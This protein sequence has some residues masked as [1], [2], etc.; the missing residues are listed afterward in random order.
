MTHILKNIDV[1]V[2]CRQ[3][4]DFHISAEVIA[5][6]QRLLAEG[7][8]G[9]SYEC[10]P[11]LFA[12]LLEPSALAS[13]ERAWSAL[14]STV[15]SPVRDVSP[16]DSL[17]V[18]VYPNDKMNPRAICRREDDGGSIAGTPPSAPC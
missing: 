15:R 16:A 2:R 3:C 11:Q 7:C 17:R 6:S 5:N 8:P 9:S 1:H 4:G 12:T 14:E 18:A 13:L 10:P